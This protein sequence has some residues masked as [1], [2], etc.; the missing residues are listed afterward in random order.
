[1]MDRKML[2]ARQRQAGK[3]ALPG[4]AR[5][6]LEV[7]RCDAMLEVFS[8]TGEERLCAPYCY[9]IDFTS[10]NRDIDPAVML[11]KP[12]TFILQAPENPEQVRKVHGVITRFNRLATSADE[13]R[14]QVCLEPRLA[15]LHHTRRCAIYQHQ[16][17]PEMVEKILRE[18]HEFR[19]QDF[20][21]T[22]VREY[23][24]RELVV[25][26]QESDLDFIQRIL[27]EVGMWYRFE[28]DGRLGIDVVRFGDN[29]RNYQYDVRLPL[30]D[31]AGMNH[32]DRDS[33]WDL[34]VEHQVVT[35]RV[36]VRDYNYR[37]A[38]NDLQYQVSRD[39]DT[40][41]IGEVY[42]YGDN[43][44]TKGEQIQPAPETAGFY[45]RL[46]HERDLY[47]QH[48]IRGQSSSPMLVPGLV[49]ELEGERPA[50]V[51]KAGVLI[52]SM[53]SS[54]RRDSN[55]RVSFSGIPYSEIMSYRPALRE[56][57][58]ISGTVPARVTS[59]WPNDTYSH[60]DK[61]GRYRIK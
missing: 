18:R 31:P 36:K 1:M 34:H 7:R 43:V 53:R 59:D 35:Q 2:R 39:R 55:Y 54:A 22:L 3:A 57:P 15:L 29:Q 26:W 33:V 4:H 27:A 9:T 56:R 60:I 51:G 20:L 28:M 6:R 17:V 16:S 30:R 25:Q 5:Y 58:V 47:R 45:A 10:P 52:V 46:H 13:T 32:N 21:F 14:Y 37:E 8:F 50:G 23:P 40:T 42:R 41:V 24:R 49:L 44:L 48:L 61:M 11:N 19:G 38:G 12:A